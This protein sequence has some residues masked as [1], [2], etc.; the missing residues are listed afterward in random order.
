M[1]VVFRKISEH[2]SA[3]MDS[4]RATA[5]LTVAVGHAHQIFI[6]PT[7]ATA[8]LFF[9]LLAQA[10]VMVFFVLSGFLIGKSISRNVSR[11]NM[12]F[13]WFEYGLDR[14]FR[15][16]PPLLFSIAI[17]SIIWL[18]APIIFPS[19]TTEYLHAASSYTRTGVHLN[20]PDIKGALIFQNGFRTTTPDMNGPLWS[21]SIEAWYY[22]LA[23]IIIIFIR[24]PIAL[25]GTLILI[26]LITRP[27]EAFF[28]YLP[29]WAIGYVLSILHNQ[30]RLRNLNKAI[31]ICS[32]FCTL[33]A[34]VFAIFLIHPSLGPNGHE[35]ITY[36]NVATG[37]AFAG[38]LAAILCGTIRVPIFLASGARYS[39][40]L[41]LVHVPI[42]L[43][44][45]GIAEQRIVGHLIWAIG[46]TVASLVMVL[47]FAKLA[48]IITENKHLYSGLIR[49]KSLIT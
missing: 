38:V 39:Y 24:R 26:W 12:H 46:V 1:R 2:Q 17:M 32:V 29:V 36:F 30:D 48:S 5:A 21:L 42:F 49:R 25:I 10:A 7:I 19:G 35:W 44:I 18:L 13:E 28:I 3:Q 40:T 8:A 34:I 6:V 14:F 47:A 11:N 16:Y 43:F 31:A 27:N 41:Y 15:L 33:S 45:F 37:L 22:V 20:W 23:A 4:I 9:G